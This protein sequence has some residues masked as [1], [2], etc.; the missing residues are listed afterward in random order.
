MDTD[1][2]ARWGRKRRA[3]ECTALFHFSIAV[4]LLSSASC[5]VVSDLAKDARYRGTNVGYQRCIDRNEDVALSAESV[6]SQCSAEHSRVIRILH[7]A[8]ASYQKPRYKSGSL[9][10]IL[11]RSIY[12]AGFV[13]NLS[14]DQIVTAVEITLTHQDNIDEAGQPIGEVVRSEN[15]WIEPGA[16]GGV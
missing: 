5:E 9:S 15:L 12:F 8:S 13:T 7:E 2:Q 16:I 14:R 10:A 3:I 6:K 11:Q 4:L 1:G